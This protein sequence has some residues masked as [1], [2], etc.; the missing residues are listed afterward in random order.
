MK[1]EVKQEAIE[2]DDDEE[3]RA[4]RMG[5][6]GTNGDRQDPQKGLVCATNTYKAKVEDIKRGQKV[7]SEN[8]QKRLDKVKY[9]TVEVIDLDSVEAID[10]EA[11]VRTGAHSID[12]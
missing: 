6:N 11:Q 8:Y 9:N 4:G 10:R 12:I 1:Q 3:V 5:Q 2:I 7:K